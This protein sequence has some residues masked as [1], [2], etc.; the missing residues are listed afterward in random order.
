M[1]T[2]TDIPANATRAQRVAD[3]PIS[4]HARRVAIEVPLST[5]PTAAAD[6]LL[7][8]FAGAYASAE[9]DP[10]GLPWA[11]LSPDPALL[12]WLNSCA[13]EH[14]RP[15]ARAIV[16]GCGLGDD[17]AELQA[18]GYDALGLDACEHA[19]AWAAE[20]FPS[21]AGSFLTADLRDPPSK[22]HKRFDL[23]VDI[24]TLQSPGRNEQDSEAMAVGL[25]RLLHPRGCVL[26]VGGAETNPTAW[27]ERP[28]SREQLAE[29]LAPAGLTPVAWLDGHANS[30]GARFVGVFNRSGCAN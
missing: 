3:A 26:V 25:A 21:C 19:V 16:V 12:R 14:V 1:A 30:D 29:L 6:A 10:S 13:S 11:R 5:P 18:R 20:R 9:R 8:P 22:L 7:Q 4:I 23:V 17:V 15:G 28:L 27:P 24:D 2:V